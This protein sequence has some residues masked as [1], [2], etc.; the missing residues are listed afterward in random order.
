M[1]LVANLGSG[2]VM[3]HCIA[4]LAQAFPYKVPGRVRNYFLGRSAVTPY[5]SKFEVPMV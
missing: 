3:T 1:F 4:H 2:N 5:T